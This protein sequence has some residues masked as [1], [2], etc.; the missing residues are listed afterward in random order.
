MHIMEAFVLPK[1]RRKGLMLGAL[2]NALKGHKG[3]VVLEVLKRNPAQ[4][5]WAKALDGLGFVK[6]AEDVSWRNHNLMQYRYKRK[7]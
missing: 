1:H 4:E 7:E 5:F 3:D 6:T 2:Q